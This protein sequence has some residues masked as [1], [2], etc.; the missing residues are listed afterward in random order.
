[1][2]FS[3]P[4]KISRQIPGTVDSYGNETLS[5]DETLSLLGE[6]Q[7]TGSN[8]NQSDRETTVSDFVLFVPAATPLDRL[9]RV[10]ID[11]QVFEVMGEPETILSPWTGTASHREARLRRTLG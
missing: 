3:R 6:L 8:E 10:T 4:L 2:R 9:D 5:T 7:Q 11:D 1:V